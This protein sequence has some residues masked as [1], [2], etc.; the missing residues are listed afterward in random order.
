[1]SNYK[2]ISHY[3]GLFGKMKGSFKLITI[4]K[5]QERAKT[6]MI[7][8]MSRLKPIVKVSRAVLVV[9]INSYRINSLIISST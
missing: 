1:M 7:K 5:T 3:K 4:L 6:R 9:I 8:Q 2:L